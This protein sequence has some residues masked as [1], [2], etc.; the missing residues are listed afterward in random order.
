MHLI[1]D[2]RR[3]LAPGIRG[4]GRDRGNSLRRIERLGETGPESGE[5]SNAATGLLWTQ[6]TG[7]S[8]EELTLRKKLSIYQAEVCHLIQQI[9]LQIMLEL[10]MLMTNP[11]LVAGANNNLR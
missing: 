4:R 9:H 7:K 2:A 1:W 5:F 6:G 3:P 11:L 10:D 8:A